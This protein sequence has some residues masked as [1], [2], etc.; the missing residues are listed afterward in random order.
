MPA[1]ASICYGPIYFS[2]SPNIK[3][4]LRTNRQ[5][6]MER[7]VTGN[8]TNYD[9]KKQETVVDVDDVKELPF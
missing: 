3:N 8:S 5:L 1:L 6:L 2:L 9:Q 7:A 4:Q